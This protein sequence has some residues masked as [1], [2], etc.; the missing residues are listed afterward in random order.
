M[1]PEVLSRKIIL[2]RIGGGCLNDI[3]PT[4]R[5][6]FGQNSVLNWRATQYSSPDYLEKIVLGDRI[7]VYHYP[8]S[9]SDQEIHS[10]IPDGYTVDINRLNDPII[11]RTVYPKINPRLYIDQ[12]TIVVTV[13]DP[14]SP[15]TARKF[16]T[17]RLILEQ[18]HIFE[19]MLAYAEHGTVG[20]AEDPAVFDWVLDLLYRGEVAVLG[21]DAALEVLQ[22]LFKYDI[23]LADIFTVF[24]RITV[25]KDAVPQLLGLI[26]LVYP[27]TIPEPIQ[28]HLTR[29][30]SD[31]P[32]LTGVG[33]SDSLHPSE[34]WWR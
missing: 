19:D 9:L 25:S 12:P 34:I 4:L 21:D 14:L 23:D 29:L 22:F 16:L 10:G 24:L 33:R 28:E 13:T 30:M 5:G 3:V 2:K 32:G 7:L 31:Q 17:H 18:N 1:A 26:K 8:P 15:S 20:L 27:E 6:I 11:F